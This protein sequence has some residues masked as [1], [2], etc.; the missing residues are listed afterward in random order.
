LV[1]LLEYFWRYLLPGK[2]DVQK[3]QAYEHKVSQLQDSIH[4]DFDDLNK[5]LLSQNGD[6][7]EW[8]RLT[9]LLLL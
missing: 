3:V 6:L 7:T 5:V 4:R 1:D 8:Q 9:K 2:S